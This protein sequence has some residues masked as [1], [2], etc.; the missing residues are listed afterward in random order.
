MRPGSIVRHKLHSDIKVGP[1]MVVKSHNQLEAECYIPGRKEFIETYDKRYLCEVPHA[2]LRV[3]T[4][5]ASKTAY[6]RQTHVSHKKIK[7]WEKA[8]HSD[9]EVVIFVDPFGDK[10]AFVVEDIYEKMQLREKI[11]VIELGYRIL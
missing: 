8:L 11:V 7:E 3:S 2:L 10:T 4:D 6:R 1:Y 9:I 5:I